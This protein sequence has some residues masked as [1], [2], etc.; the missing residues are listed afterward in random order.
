MIPIIKRSKYRHW[1]GWLW[2][3]MG[4]C[5]HCGSKNVEDWDDSKFTNFRFGH[6]GKHCLDCD[7]ITL[8]S[9]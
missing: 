4:R 1:V 5:W 9:T 7:C 6:W 2:K 3:L 8:Y